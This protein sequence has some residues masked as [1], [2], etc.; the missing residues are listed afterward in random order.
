MEAANDA[1]SQDAQM[2]PK[3]VK[4]EGGKRCNEAGC[5]NGAQGKTYKC[6]SHGGGGKLCTEPGCIIVAHSRGK[7]VAHGGGKRCTE[8]GC[9]KIAISPTD[10]CTAHGGGARCTE[11]GCKK[12]AQSPTDKCVAHGGGER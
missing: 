12:S 7:C 10:K 11:P 9:M 4:H 5:T 2:V 8:P 3:C 6:K 1:L